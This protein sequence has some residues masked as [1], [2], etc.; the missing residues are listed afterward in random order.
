[1]ALD[2]MK[3]HSFLYLFL[4]GTDIPINAS[5]AMYHVIPTAIQTPSRV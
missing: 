2:E 4:S 5:V 3:T 1:M